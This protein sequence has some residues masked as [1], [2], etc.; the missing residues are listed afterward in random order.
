MSLARGREN[1]SAHDIQLEAGTRRA[2]G[3]AGRGAAVAHTDLAPALQAAGPR[4]GLGLS[5]Q[6]RLSRGQSLRWAA[7]AS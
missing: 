2:E 4:A 7:C 1:G 6:Q 3:R 5:F